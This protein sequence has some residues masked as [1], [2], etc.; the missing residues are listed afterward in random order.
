MRDF[1]LTDFFLS[2][3]VALLATSF[4]EKHAARNGKEISDISGSVMEM[5]LR[6]SWPGNV[7]ELENTIERAVI[8]CN[9]DKIQVNHL[10]YLNQEKE[11]ELLGR[12]LQERMT[13]AQ[14]TRLYARMTLNEQDGNKKEACKVLGIN[15]RT[16]QSRISDPGK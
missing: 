11:T 15:F 7:R 9:S 4:L 12:A 14:L 5:L 2:V 10:L 16:L 8:L 13:E 1:F 6:F 3:H